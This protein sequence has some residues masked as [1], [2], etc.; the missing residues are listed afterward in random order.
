MID[1]L[2]GQYGVP[3]EAIATAWILRHPARWQVVL[4]TT[5]PERVTAAAPSGPS[6]GADGA[7]RSIEWFSG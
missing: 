6:R 3:A 7:R 1:R 5:T 2:A 4:G